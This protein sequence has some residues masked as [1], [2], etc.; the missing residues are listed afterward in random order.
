MLKVHIFQTP[1]IDR[2]TLQQ[3]ILSPHSS[4]APGSF[5]NCGAAPCGPWCGTAALPAVRCPHSTAQGWDRG[6]WCWAPLEHIT[7]VYWS[8]WSSSDKGPRFPIM[9][10][11]P[12][13][14]QITTNTRERW[15]EYRLQTAPCHLCTS[16]APLQAQCYSHSLNLC[17]LMP[18]VVFIYQ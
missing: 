15:Q 8:L 2:H 9:L 13:T 17:K 4:P 1:K 10:S 3:H 5:S 12:I 16:A 11:G 14:E 7:A 18:H 6:H